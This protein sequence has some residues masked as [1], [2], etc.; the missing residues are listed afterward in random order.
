M[1]LHRLPYHLREVHVYSSTLAGASPFDFYQKKK[2]KVSN[3]TPAKKYGR[4][5]FDFILYFKKQNK[6]KRQR[7]A[8]CVI[9]SFL[10]NQNKHSRTLFFNFEKYEIIL[11]HRFSHTLV[12]AL[13]VL[14]PKTS[15]KYHGFKNPKIKMGYKTQYT[16][17]QYIWE[18]NSRH[19]K[20]FKNKISHHPKVNKIC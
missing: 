15:F 2:K 6:R 8:S 3:N 20:K 10:N 5:I 9:F 4:K 1:S 19:S 13:H 12:N 18:P 7:F 17:H 14:T 11:F 16:F